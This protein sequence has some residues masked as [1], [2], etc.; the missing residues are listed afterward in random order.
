MKKTITRSSVFSYLLVTLLSLTLGANP[1]ASQGM[2]DPELAMAR[3][4]GVEGVKRMN[5]VIRG[6]MGGDPSFLNEASKRE[7]MSMLRQISDYEKMSE[8]E[9]QA[10]TRYMRVQMTGVATELMP[11]FW[12][13]ALWAYRKQ[14]FFKS[15]MRNKVEQQYLRY[16]VISQARVDQNDEII[17]K[18]AKRSPINVQGTEVIFD[19]AVLAATIENIK[20]VQQ[21]IEWLFSSE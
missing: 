20:P 12:E 14:E 3:V 11:L 6:V 2:S 4:V 21:R 5:E 17:V 15:T 13:D 16:G 1:A 19:E 9:F 7:V 18:I 8:D 10:F